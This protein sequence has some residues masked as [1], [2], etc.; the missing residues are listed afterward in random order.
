M[1]NIMQGLV[2]LTSADLSCRPDC[3]SHFVTLSALSRADGT[4]SNAFC[5]APVEKEMI[6]SGLMWQFDMSES[7][8]D[9]VRD[10]RATSDHQPRVSSD[11]S[12][13]TEGNDQSLGEQISRPQWFI[14]LI[15]A[16]RSKKLGTKV[17]C[18]KLCGILFTCWVSVHDTLTE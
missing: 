15:N 3:S 12:P 2:Q 8:R 10:R 14:K 18:R 7:E 4:W 5:R 6:C 11:I 17:C 1:N 16:G 9:S 13:W